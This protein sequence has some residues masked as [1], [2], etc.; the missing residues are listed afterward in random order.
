MTTAS[1]QSLQHYTQTRACTAQCTCVQGWSAHRAHCCPSPGAK[2]AAKA[3][4]AEEHVEYLIGIKLI[5][6]LV[7]A[8]PPAAPPQL[9]RG[10]LVPVRSLQYL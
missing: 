8:A 5:L 1:V 2:A 7:H 6:L 3:A 10:I 4:A 9:L